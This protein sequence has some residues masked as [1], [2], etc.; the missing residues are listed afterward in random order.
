LLEQVI[1][2]SC[3]ALVTAVYGVA[4]TYLVYFCGFE[5]HQASAPIEKITKNLKMKKIFNVSSYGV[6]AN[7]IESYK[8]RVKSLHEIPRFYSF[9]LL[10]FQS[11]ELQVSK[12]FLI[13]SKHRKLAVSTAQVVEL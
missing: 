3:I 9:E 5:H 7:V 10:R 12:K 1:D 4:M 8:N 6:I 2:W 13:L 11:Y